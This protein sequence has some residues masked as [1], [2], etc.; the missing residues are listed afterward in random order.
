VKVRPIKQTEW[1]NLADY[2]MVKGQLLDP[3]CSEALY[4][5][6]K[7]KWFFHFIFKKKSII[8]MGRRMTM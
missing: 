2:T 8:G 3:K 1:S 5:I 6:G 7:L 4:T